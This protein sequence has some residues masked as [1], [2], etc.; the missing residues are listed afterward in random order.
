[1][2]SIAILVEFRKTEHIIFLGEINTS[3]DGFERSSDVAESSIVDEISVE[4][5]CPSNNPV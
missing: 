3:D 2:D 4:K 1:L 5:R